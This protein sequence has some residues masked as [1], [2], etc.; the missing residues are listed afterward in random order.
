[1]ILGGVVEII[2]GVKAERRRLEGIAKPLT[3]IETKVRDTAARHRPR[4]ARTQTAT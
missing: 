3:A 4:A 1:M 2:F